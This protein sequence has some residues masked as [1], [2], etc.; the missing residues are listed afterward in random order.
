VDS[1]PAIPH[2]CQNLETKII[3]CHVAEEQF[4]GLLFDSHSLKVYKSQERGHMSKP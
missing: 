2:P 3:V 4:S 1:Y